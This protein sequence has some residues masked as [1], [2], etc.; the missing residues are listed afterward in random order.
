[1]KYK[2]N[3]YILGK[4]KGKT[5]EGNIIFIGDFG[6]IIEN[7]Y[8]EQYGVLYTEVI[9]RKRDF[10]YVPWNKPCIL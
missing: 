8:G 5:V 2:L 10:K 4:C 9:C 6:Y 1:M 7:E 3:D